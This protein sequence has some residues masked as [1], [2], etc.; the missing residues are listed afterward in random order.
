[1]RC[2]SALCVIWPNV[3]VGSRWFWCLPYVSARLPGVADLQHERPVGRQQLG[4]PGR[5][6]RNSL[7]VLLAGVVAVLLIA[8]EW[9]RR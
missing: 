2:R 9:E 6:A 7:E 8:V 5:Q 4:R 3:L 1:V